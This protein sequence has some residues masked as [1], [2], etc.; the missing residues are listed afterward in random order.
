MEIVL[1]ATFVF[2]FLWVLTRAMGKRELAEMT[3]LEM[4]LL[5]TMG[6]LVQQ[7][8]TQEDMSLTGAVMAVGTIAFWILVFSY[9]GFRWRRAEDVIAGFPVVVMRDGQVIQDA[10][11]IE[12]IP[13][14]ELMEAARSHGIDDLTKVRVAILEPDGRFSFITDDKQQDEPTERH[15]L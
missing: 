11:N 15:E 7:G 12:R 10:L 14:D 4:V 1:R 2:F 5:V 6:D 8:V 3:A 9:T 13:T